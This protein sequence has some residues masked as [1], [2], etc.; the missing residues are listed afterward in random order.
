MGIFL[1]ISTLYKNINIAI[2]F[3]ILRIKNR[4]YLLVLKYLN[5]KYFHF[6]SQFIS[7]FR[8]SSINE[9]NFMFVSFCTS[10]SKNQYIN[11][12]T[13]LTI[14]KDKIRLTFSMQFNVKERL[15]EQA[16]VLKILIFC[17]YQYTLHIPKLQLIQIFCLLTTGMYF[18]NICHILFSMLKKIVAEKRNPRMKILCTF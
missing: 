14:H 1:N 18:I 4:I 5:S 6:A 7:S 15:D 9:I 10:F 8:I 12:I 13:F 16:S 3:I 17:I 11:N 2:I